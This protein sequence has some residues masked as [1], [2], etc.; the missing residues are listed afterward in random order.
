M[1]L[2]AMR[3]DRS[4]H[5]SFLTEQPT[6]GQVYWR[7]SQHSVARSKQAYSGQIIRRSQPQMQVNAKSPITARA[8]VVG[9]ALQARSTA[10]LTAAHVAG[11]PQ[12][13]LP[14]HGPPLNLPPHSIRDSV[15]DTGYGPWG[16]SA[17]P[18][19]RLTMVSFLTKPRLPLLLSRC[20]H[21]PAVMSRTPTPGAGG[22]CGLVAPL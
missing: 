7:G 5:T 13:T 20:K 9:L 4:L 17:A 3:E 22:R 11:C 10:V 1:Q 15:L 12:L 18:V 16:P 6:E 2:E 19:A 8:C 14:P 21:S